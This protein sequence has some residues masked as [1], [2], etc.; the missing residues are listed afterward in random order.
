[1]VIKPSTHTFKGRGK[2]KKPPAAFR[3]EVRVEKP[4]L[5]DT[6]LVGSGGV[7]KKTYATDGEH[8]DA[9][10]ADATT[11]IKDSAWPSTQTTTHRRSAKST[12]DMLFAHEDKHERRQ[13]EKC[14]PR[15]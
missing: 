3:R 14:H 9:G 7:R 1:M 15:E 10:E 5:E 8:G 6:L 11:P 12:T 2:K 13:S 4:S